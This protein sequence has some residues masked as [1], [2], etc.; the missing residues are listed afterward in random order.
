[1]W[2]LW[3][4]K[5]HWG[6]FSPSTSVCPANFYSTD[7]STLKKKL[8]QGVD[9]Q[10]DHSYTWIYFI[11]NSLLS[12]RNH[13]I[14]HWDTALHIGHYV[15]RRLWYIK[16]SYNYCYFGYRSPYC[17]ALLCSALNALE[18]PPCEIK[19]FDNAVPPRPTYVRAIKG[20]I[21]SQTG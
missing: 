13:Y 2:D 3:W 7:C 18:F 10:M 15:V 21:R 16:R 5:W 14:L 19:T 1:M 20:R 17:L 9:S 6:R 4:T 11:Q 12:E 8:L